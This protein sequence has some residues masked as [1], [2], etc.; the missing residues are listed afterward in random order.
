MFVNWFKNWFNSSL[1]K[2]TFKE[3]YIFFRYAICETLYM[4]LISFK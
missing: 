2:A 1:Q 4:H 3:K